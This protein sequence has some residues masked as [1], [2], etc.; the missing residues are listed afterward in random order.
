MGE[1][2]LACEILK[3]LNPPG[4]LRILL[5]TYINQGMEILERCKS[6]AMRQNARLSIHTAY[7]PFDSPTLM[8]R[9]V[10]TVRP[11]IMLL[12]ESELWPGLLRAC[13]HHRVKILVA[14]ARMTARSL[15]RYRIWPALW[16][17]LRP[18]RVLAISPENAA[19]FTALFGGDGVETMPNI[20]FDRMGNQDSPVK[21]EKPLT[22]LFP[23]DTRLIILGSIREQEE[24]DV[25]KMISTILDHSRQDRQPVNI[26]LF[27]RHMRR[28]KKWETI[29]EKLGYAWY[30]R[31][32]LTGT[33][34]NGCIILW[35]TMGEMLPAYELA[36]AA[37][38]G[39]S[40]APLGGQN[41]LE[42]LTCGL[43][44]VI[45]PHWSNFY[46]VGREIINQR[47]VLQAQ[48]WREAAELLLECSAQPPRREQTRQEILTYVE[49]RRGGTAKTCAII[50][51]LL[52]ESKN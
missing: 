23:S 48:N 29:L 27:P 44:P 10:T 6:D 41:F 49:N 39:G 33:V 13:K 30:L 11:R 42:P 51:Q 35:D 21:N 50:N 31:S 36:R 32:R 1:A 3:K 26:A 7:L 12:L 45:G 46:W 5:T 14:N 52:R 43:K 38:V 25:I 17:Y 22:R 4:P 16:R 9:A 15:N 20:K 40:L 8:D 19:N 28:V 47:L 37:F 18:D 24:S 34:E 2:F